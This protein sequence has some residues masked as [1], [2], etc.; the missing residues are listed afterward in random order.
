M[1]PL[2][3]FA[4]RCVNRLIR[5]VGA[6]INPIGT[7][8]S[9]EWPGFPDVEPWVAEIIRE[10]RPFTMTSSERIS[11]LCHAVRYIVRNEIPGDIVECGV[12]RG[13]SMMAVAAAFLKAGD[14]T[15]TLHLFDTF[16]G[17]PP[18]SK[19]DV[20]R[21]SGKSAAALLAEAKD[22][23]AWIWAHAP[24]EEVRTN[25]AATSYPHESAPALSRAG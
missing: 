5:Y 19:L 14:A 7:G 1:R 11:A 22:R 20:A 18:P 10:V 21:H 15:R 16:E 17:M 12:W 24:L 6:E 9:A 23:S 4:A 25:L 8:A 13:G 3:S 2:K